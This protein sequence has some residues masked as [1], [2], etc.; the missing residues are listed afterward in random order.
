MQNL[1]LELGH[2]WQVWDRFQG[3]GD[4][5]RGGLGLKSCAV[6]ETFE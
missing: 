1:W 5:Y 4:R 6:R 3:I 2:N